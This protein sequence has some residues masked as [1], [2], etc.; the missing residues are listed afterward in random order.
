MSPY[1][2]GGRDFSKS[3]LDTNHIYLAEH[4]LL[5]KSNNKY[6][7]TKRKTELGTKI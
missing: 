5:C 6:H 1:T 4:P 3:L 7:G 2:L